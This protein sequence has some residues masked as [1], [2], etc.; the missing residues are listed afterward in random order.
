[1]AEK[2]T[3]YQAVVIADAFSLIGELFDMMADFDEE[4]IRRIQ[5]DPAMS[6]VMNSPEAKTLLRF[7]ARREIKQFRKTAKKAKKMARKWEKVT[8]GY[9]PMGLKG[10]RLQQLAGARHMLRDKFMTKNDET[11]TAAERVQ[12][13][14]A[15]SAAI[16]AVDKAIMALS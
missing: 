12:L 13:T 11:Y 16:E 1:M 5:A 14:G 3:Q 8:G 4:R 15:R 9:W 2:I 10:E 6:N 7:G